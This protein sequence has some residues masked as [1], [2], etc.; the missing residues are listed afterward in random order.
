MERRFE[1][2]IMKYPQA[3]L[4]IEILERSQYRLATMELKEKNPSNIREFSCIG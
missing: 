3:V 1:D 2:D 4:A